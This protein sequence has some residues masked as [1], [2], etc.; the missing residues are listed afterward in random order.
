MSLKGINVLVVDDK[1]AMRQMVLRTLLE[2][3]LSGLRVE[4]A[5]NG[6]D[7]LAKLADVDPDV[8][9]SDWRMPEMNGV[10]LLRE[11][12]SRGSAVKFGF[13][14]PEAPTPP[15]R[16]RAFEAGAQFVLELPFSVERLRD[17]LCG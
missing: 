4:E 7:A 17:V 8:I 14:M 12:R 3:G 13:V 10:E 2:T 5:E 6:S 11:L 15:M 1:K 16:E 9:L